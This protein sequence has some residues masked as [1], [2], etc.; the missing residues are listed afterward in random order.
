[1][2][3]LKYLYGAIGGLGVIRGHR[4]DQGRPK[5]R[6]D[7]GRPDA[8][9]RQYLLTLCLQPHVR[10]HRTTLEEG[11]RF[12]L[13]PVSHCYLTHAY[14]TQHI[15]LFFLSQPA[16]HTRSHALARS[17]GTRNAQVHHLVPQNQ[18]LHSTETTQQRPTD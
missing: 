16:R 13:C 8:P 4:D 18:P 3:Q 10:K 17:T 12:P 15:S 14:L 5:S 9:I 1:M 6:G 2:R 11:T 7:R